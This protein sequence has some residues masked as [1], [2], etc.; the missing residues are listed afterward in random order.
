MPIIELTKEEKEKS[1]Y[2][3]VN[4]QIQPQWYAW[5]IHEAYDCLNQHK[6]SKSYGNHMLLIV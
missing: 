6:I 3:R 1:K 4:C 2:I 5:Q